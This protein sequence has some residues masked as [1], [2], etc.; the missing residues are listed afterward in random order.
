MPGGPCRD[1]LR[2][3]GDHQRGREAREGPDCRLADA[4]GAQG[5]WML[6]WMRP[7]PW[8]YLPHLPGGVDRPEAQENRGGVVSSTWEQG[9]GDG[10]GDASTGTELDG[11]SRPVQDS[12][13][14]A[15]QAIQGRALSP[16]RVGDGPLDGAIRGPRLRLGA[17]AADALARA[18]T[19]LDARNAH[20]RRSF[21]DHEER[22]LK[23]K[24]MEADTL[25]GP[26][27][28]ARLCALRQRIRDRA[29]TSGTATLG[30]L[31]AARA[32]GDGGGGAGNQC[33]PNT[34]EVSKMHHSFGKE[35]AGNAAEALDEAGISA[36]DARGSSSGAE[37]GIDDIEVPLAHATAAAARVAAWHSDGGL[38]ADG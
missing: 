24:N 5:S 21:A 15:L 38:T 19:R 20:L 9:D 10:G 17:R 29:S 28:A 27:A 2:D 22:V 25:P 14:G 32:S 26:S 13:S 12:R 11:E 7:P 16:G 33:A 31:Q 23:R 30:R 37:L 8:L 34:N 1:E 4:R 36:G 6:P 18:Q 35:E 3:R